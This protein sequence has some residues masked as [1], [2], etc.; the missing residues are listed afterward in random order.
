MSTPTLGIALPPT[1]YISPPAPTVK[2]LTANGMSVSV[3]HVIETTSDSLNVISLTATCG[4]S[5]HSHKHMIGSGDG[6]RPAPLTPTTAQ[7]LLDSLRQQVADEAS[8]KE[9]TRLAIAQLV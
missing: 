1:V 9:S 4:Q 2:T 8:W 7:A 3:A 5:T 6:Q